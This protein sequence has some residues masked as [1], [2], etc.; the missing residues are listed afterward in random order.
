MPAI[1]NS[2]HGG[3]VRRGLVPA[4]ALLRASVRGLAPA[5]PSGWLGFCVRTWIAVVLALA[6]AFWLQ[7]DDASSAAVCVA[8]LAQ[9]T[10]GQSLS[11]AIYRLG[12]TVV[13]ALVALLLVA[14]FP[15]ARFMLLG[16]IGLWLALCTMIGTLLRDFRSYAALL[17]GYTVAIVGLPVIDDPANAWS[18]TV[19]RVVA[20][21]LGVLATLLVNSLFGSPDGWKT[22]LRTLRDTADRVFAIADDAVHGRGLP[23]E[24]ALAALAVGITALGTQAS[25]TRTELEDG[26]DRAA[27]ARSALL[28]LID[29]LACARALAH[30]LA[31][32]EADPALA[33]ALPAVADAAAHGSEA[34]RE[35]PGLPAEAFLLERSMA[36]GRH[37]RWVEDGL[38]VLAEGGRPLREVRIRHHHDL[39]A[40]GLNGVRVLIAFAIGAAISILSGMPDATLVLIEIAALCALVS[41]NPN[42]TGFAWGTLL[43]APLAVAAAALVEFGLLTQGSALPLLAM[44]LIAPVFVACILVLDPR[45]GSVGFIMLVFTFVILNPANVQGFDVPSFVDSSVLFLL[46]AILIFLSM[47]LILPVQPRQRLLRG[48]VSIAG[49][50][51]RTLAGAVPPEGAAFGVRNYDRLAQLHRWNGL[52][53]D[54]GSRR[55]VLARLVGLTDLV[56]ALARARRGLADAA[57]IPALRETAAAAGRFDARDVD[58]TLE[59]MDRAASTLLRQ[60]PA[61]P[62]AQHA[63]LLRSVSGLHGA[64]LLLRTHRRML[65]LTGALG[66]ARR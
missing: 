11:K 52:I 20:I 31:H 22:L 64:A 65:V 8:I 66:S 23:D 2:S 19:S 50:L 47:V 1:G 37:R 5:L 21:A 44:A 62:A 51:G 53:G 32:G 13:G 9:P 17:S 28:G 33:A 40:V 56:G 6:A 14:M 10:R 58:A 29:M 16:G 48:A 15:Q 59:R 45:T 35:V 27:G 39:F 57:A 24:T 61:L 54:A 12:G 55:F 41:T 26:R 36:L 49:E 34:L 18:S 43:G 4:S 63:T 3:W 46:S 25:Y 60:G 38:M 42:P 7:I 30:G